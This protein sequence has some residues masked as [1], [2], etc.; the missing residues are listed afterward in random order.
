MASSRTSPV[1]RKS[2][3]RPG[4]AMIACT[5]APTS[6]S[7]FSREAPPYTHAEHTPS[8]PP[9]RTHSF[10]ICSASSRVGARTTPVVT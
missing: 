2:L 10:S 5:P 7:C 8:G 4:V 1:S 3:S 9:N 6:A